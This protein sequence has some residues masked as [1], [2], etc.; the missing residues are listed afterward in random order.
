M[1]NSFN[2]WPIAMS[3]ADNL[4]ECLIRDKFVAKHFGTDWATFWMAIWDLKTETP[5]ISKAQKSYLHAL[6]I[7]HRRRE[8][9]EML[10]RLGLKPII[11]IKDL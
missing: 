4:V 1:N 11:E 5:K 6:I 10:M 8:L 3:Q 7:Y 9:T 2:D